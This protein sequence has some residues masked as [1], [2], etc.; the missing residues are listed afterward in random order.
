MERGLFLVGHGM[1]AP[2]NTLRWR[3]EVFRITKSTVLRWNRREQGDLR[4]LFG[5]LPEEE[6][7]ILI[8]KLLD[9]LE[10]SSQKAVFSRFKKL[11]VYCERHPNNPTPL[12]LRQ[13]YV[14]GYINWLEKEGKIRASTAPA[15]LAAISTVHQ[16]AGYTTFSAFDKTSS[17]LLDSWRKR[18]SDG[19]S[20]DE[21][22]TLPTS[23][24]RLLE[25]RLRDGEDAAFL[26]AGLVIVVML[27]FFSRADS[28]L[29]VKLADLSVDLATKRIIFRERRFK[30]RQKETLEYRIRQFH[31]GGVPGILAALHRFIAW[32][33]KQD[34]TTSQDHLFLLPHESGALTRAQLAACLQRVTTDLDYPAVVTLHTLR[35]TVP[36]RTI[37]LFD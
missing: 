36:A 24:F 25:E 9:S 14:Y 11:M 1:G 33:L 7:S 13:Y 26:R 28:K 27:L 4:G 6:Q 20:K 16:L 37:R 35:K 30:R 3:T 34:N 32:R 22:V 17:R 15:Y 2:E 19:T 29:D 21:I 5:D 8:H 12:P 10:V 31:G 18:T 23:F